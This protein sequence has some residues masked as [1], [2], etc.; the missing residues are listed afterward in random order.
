MI[1]YL[2]CESLAHTD[3]WYPYPTGRSSS[4]P[5]RERR[6]RLRGELREGDQV[7]GDGQCDPRGLQLPLEEGEE[8][9]GAQNLGYDVYVVILGAIHK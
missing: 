9:G 4:L 7:P 8:L 5:L 2:Y 3:T 1:I 6:L